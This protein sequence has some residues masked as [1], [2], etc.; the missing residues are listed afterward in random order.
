MWREGWRDAG[1]EGFQVGLS[2]AVEEEVGDNEII[3]A[4]ERDSEC[5]GLMGVEVLGCV[6]RGGFAALAEELQHGG[7]SVDCIGVEGRVLREELGE[8]TAVSVADYQGLFLIEKAEEEVEA[9]AFEGSAEGEVFEPAIGACD[10]VEVGLGGPHQFR[11]GRMR[12]GV[13]RTRSARLRRVSR[14]VWW[15][16]WWRRRRDAAEAAIAQGISLGA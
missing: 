8:E 1:D 7:A 2:E 15:L 5:A 16:R 11:N 4:S 6:G 14:A 9:A 3:G 10:V 13:V 12:S